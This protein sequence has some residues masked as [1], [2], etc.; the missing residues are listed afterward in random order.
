MC[1]Y[2][3]TYIYI[4][5]YIYIYM[6]GDAA[7][8]CFAPHARPASGAVES[9]F[10]GTTRLIRLVAFAAFLRHHLLR[11]VKDHHSPP[12]W[13]K[14]CVRQVALDKWFSLIFSE[15]CSENHSYNTT[16]PKH[17]PTIP[18][19]HTCYTLSR[20]KTTCVI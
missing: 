13:K 19:Y 15:H 7:G 14:P 1:I 16:S 10:C 17:V 2:T 9:A 4:Y 8:G 12:R 18:K 11:C 20:L 3:Y 5:I 6:A